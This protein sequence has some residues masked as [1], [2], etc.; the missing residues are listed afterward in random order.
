VGRVLWKRI[1]KKSRFIAL[2]LSFPAIH[3]ANN[4]RGLVKN[5]KIN[6]TIHKTTFKK[7]KDNYIKDDKQDG[8]VIM[9]PIQKVVTTKHL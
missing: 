4:S 6:P 7:S 9:E 2:K 5:K 1:P 3:R 8:C